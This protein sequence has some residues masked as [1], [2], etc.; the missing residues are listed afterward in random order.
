MGRPIAPWFVGFILLIGPATFFACGDVPYMGGDCAVTDDCESD[1]QY[2]PGTVCVDERCVCGDPGKVIC[3]ARGE[4]GSR[5][6]QDPDCFKACLTCD[7]CAEGTEEGTEKC[8]GVPVPPV[9]CESDAECPGPPDPRCGAGRCVDGAC[10]VEIH[11]G[12]IA[13]QLRGDCKIE[14]CTADG[15]VVGVPAQDI[16]DDGNQCTLDVC[17]VDGPQHLLLNEVT[18]PASGEGRCHDG[19]CVQC[20]ATDASL[21]CPGGRACDGVWC[22]PEHCVNDAQDA[23]LGETGF[24]CGGPCRPCQAGDRCR[25]ASDC[26]SGVCTNES[27]MIPNCSDGVKNGLESGVDC[28]KLFCPRCEPGGG[29]QTGA[30][31]K[32]GVCW[33]GACEAPTCTD[34]VK[35]G[36]EAGVDCGGEGCAAPCPE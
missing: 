20:V 25:V 17:D 21:R 7:E 18:C 9:G 14:E 6:E 11:E 23:G 16:Y 12:P 35:N 22:V 13:S 27:C 2:V 10:A 1:H 30:D 32:S 33:A 36:D 5:G 15:R 24:N 3:C 8:S 34:G 31:C 29:C 19:A 28:G 4:E 26:M